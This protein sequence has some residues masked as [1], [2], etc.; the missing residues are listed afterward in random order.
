M[1]LI[2]LKLSQRKRR[3]KKISGNNTACLALF[4]IPFTLHLPFILL[5]MFC[6]SACL[7]FIMPRSSLIIK[8]YFI[9]IFSFALQTM[10]AK[11]PLLC[12]QASWVQVWTH[13]SSEIVLKDIVA[14]VITV[15]ELC[16][17]DGACVRCVCCIS[18]GRCLRRSVG[19]MLGRA[20]ALS[21]SPE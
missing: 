21:D 19:M 4:C 1:K 7:S 2:C 10:T 16:V 11:Y 9:H 12:L 18:C 3:Q 15:H 6:C 13:F 5:L 17:C 20:D 14:G 8:L